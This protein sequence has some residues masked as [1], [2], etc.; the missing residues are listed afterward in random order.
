MFPLTLVRPA[1]VSLAPDFL[2]VVCVFSSFLEHTHVN[3]HILEPLPKPRAARG[4]T[5]TSSEGGLHAGLPQHLAH[6]Q[7][8]HVP[9]ATP[10]HQLAAS[11]GG[12]QQKQQGSGQ[13]AGGGGQGSPAGRGKRPVPLPRRLPSISSPSASQAPVGQSPV[14]QHAPVSVSVGQPTSSAS[15]Q[16]PEPG[17]PT[18]RSQVQSRGSNPRRR[19][20]TSEVPTPTANFKS[21]RRVL[22]SEVQRRSSCTEEGPGEKTY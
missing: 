19:S 12:Q 14:R 13:Q 17:T 8:G 16:Q 21:Y 2:L 10:A 3:C 4:S 6:Q 1:D 7:A 9:T 18:S 11:P 5:G 15:A 22:P 20:T